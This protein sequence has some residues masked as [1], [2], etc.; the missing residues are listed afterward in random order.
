MNDHVHNHLPL[1]ATRVCYLQIGE[2][3]MGPLV[4]GTLSFLQI[5]FPTRHEDALALVNAFVKAIGQL[6]DLHDIKDM[7]D[8][9]NHLTTTYL[10]LAKAL[11]EY[12]RLN[13]KVGTPLSSG[14]CC[15]CCLLR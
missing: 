4:A 7:R 3:Q 5:M 14:G 10:G 12:H 11:E 2:V 13:Q 8:D 15:C 1:P 6:L 9:I